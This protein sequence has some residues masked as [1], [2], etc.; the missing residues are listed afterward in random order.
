LLILDRDGTLI[1]K[2]DF[3]GKNPDWKDELKL[4]DKVIDFISYIQSKHNTAKIVVSNQAGVARDYFSCKTVEEINNY[5]HKLLLKKEIN[6]DNW[7]YCPYVDSKYAKLKKEEIDFNPEFVSEKTKRKPNLD[8]VHDGLKVINKRLGDL[9]NIVVVGDRHEDKE[10]AE[11]L[12]V[13]FIS[14]NN[15]TSEEMIREFEQILQNES[16]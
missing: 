7:Q 6:I 16:K 9:N 11:K 12:N 5:I 8:M 13:G 2:K 14:V 15:K 4:K 1:E 10:L 3:L